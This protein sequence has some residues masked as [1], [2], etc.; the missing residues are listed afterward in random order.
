M[1][2]PQGESTQ[3]LL[4]ALTSQLQS[5]TVQPN[6]SA[7]SLKLPE[8]WTTSPE[9]WFARVEAQFGTKNISTDQTK[10]DYV[11]SALDVKTAEEVQDV[12]V[13]PPDANKYSVL[14][15][16]LLK[17]FGKSQAQRDNELLNLNGL[18]DRKPTALLR[19]INALNEDPQSLKRALFLSNLP[20][21]IR[22][23][24]AG[25][26]FSDIQK[27]AEAADRI[28][29]TRGA[30]VQ[31]VIH[32]ADSSPPAP[33]TI[34][35]VSRPRFQPQRRPGSKAPSTQAVCYYHLKFGPQARRCQPGCK[36]LSLLPSGNDN[37]S[38]AAAGNPHQP[39]TFSVVDRLS[40][41]SYLVDTGAEVS[42]YPASVQERKSQP[43][44]STLTAANGTSIHTWGKR[45]VFLA[46]GQRGQYQHEFY[47][48]DVT[49][50]IL[51]ADFFIKH[52]L[53]IDLRGKR[54]LS[55]DN[56]SIL[57]R[58]TRSPL[59]L[60]GLGFPLKHEYDSLLQ[61]FPELLT[62]HFH[63]CKNKH[64]VE[65]HIIT[66]GPQT[67]SRARRLD[68]A[69][70][71]AAKAEFLQM[72][73]MGIIRRSKSAWSS[74][75]H[76]VPKADGNWRPCGDYR[77]L[78]ASTDDDRYPLP[79][80]QDFN[81]HLAGCKV[82]SK[83]DLIRGYHQIPMAP[84][85]IQKT[86][87]VT[88]FGLWEFLRMPFGSKNAAQSFQRLI[89]G[90]LRDIPFAFVYLDDI[91]LHGRCIKHCCRRPT[92][93]TQGQS[94]VP[95]AFF[96][97][98][99]SDAEKK[100]SAF[101][102][103]LLASYSAVKHFR[104]FL[105]G[106]PFTLYTDHKP[107]TFA[108][109][110][111]TDRSP[112][113]T[114]HLAFIAEFT[115]DIRHIK[116]KFNVVADALSRITTTSNA[117]DTINLCPVSISHPVEVDWTDFAQ[118]AKD[119]IQSGEMA[120]YRT[121]T[122]GLI[123]KDIDIGPS[124]LFCDTS[125]GVTRLVLPVSWT[126]PV[127]N[128]IHGLSHPGVRPTQKA[129]AQRFVW[130]GMKRDIRQ[131]CKECPDCQASK[132]HRHTHSALTKRPQPSDRF[133]SLHVDLVGPLPESHG[134]TYLFTVI[135]RFTRWP[136]AVPLPDAQASTC[137]TALLHHWVA[138]FG[139]P[140]DITSERGRQF[141]S[142]LWTQLN[143]L[144]AINANTTT[145]YHP[146]A[147][148]MVERLHRQLKASL[149]ARTTSSNWFDELPMVLL[150]IRSSWRVDPGCSPAELVYGSTLRIPGEFL[151]PHDA[152]TVEPD[153]PFLRHLQQ[154]MRSVQPPT[155]QFHG[156]PSVYVPANLAPAKFVYV[157]K[158]SHKH[159]LQRPYDGPYLVLNKSDK[160]FTVDIKGRPETI[161]ID[162]LKAAF[163]T[164]LTTAGDTDRPPEPPS[165][166]PQANSP[167]QPFLP[168]SSPSM[169][170]LVTKTRSGRSIRLPSR[171]R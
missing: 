14:K 72:E 82:F 141:T 121:A 118:L 150:G 95:L 28:W 25:Q 129:I 169:D 153:L 33:V 159:P 158:D 16:A 151:Q 143:S 36:F 111:E 137:A 2:Q 21:D 77:R 115:T 168:T 116:G 18:D 17:A 52:G 87:V 122:T 148:V 126:R 108:F 49:R 20:A 132:I 113:Q 162:R 76:M 58:E 135:D 13:N 119:Q 84:S 110:S 107:L 136:E 35:A 106:R 42:V 144:L 70:L 127:F 89:D 8:F 37:A 68:Q 134:M 6:I 44:S 43:P 131:W 139:V 1:S 11:V 45:K 117:A 55:I 29:E 155:P 63:Q 54:L 41:R 91:L 51:G 93:T 46:I 156:Q 4:A 124:T 105:E 130:H 149:K 79:H 152:R 92:R 171:F 78:N 114:R 88:P 166:E 102:R 40:G 59:T 170:N 80:I 71:S 56:M 32:T 24:L 83:I 85:S 9:V 10:Y 31:Q 142:A 97:R 94:W 99:L 147:N 140:E 160:F 23:I 103:E 101:D 104:H 48:A 154:T 50:P 81:N 62:P 12:L 165:A 112:R 145:A 161:S 53:A 60:S 5:M 167:P 164:Q 39:N 157:R 38:V 61:Q 133:R 64:G 19:K 7:V 96:S 22:S 47:L 30:C 27:L 26:N 66:Q 100:Y 3:A 73:D 128:K 90:I 67:H 69:K 109:C 86:A 98:K 138:R 125:L 163:V 146:Q 57:L 75:L 120:S 34:E 74:P 65:H 123:L 15:R